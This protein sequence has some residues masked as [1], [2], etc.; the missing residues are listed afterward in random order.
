M[1]LVWEHT[2]GKRRYQI[3]TAGRS[4]RLYTNG[5]L[6]SQYHPGHVFNGGVWDL[7]GLPAMW[8]AD[9]RLSGILML[10][11]GGGTVI[12][13]LHELVEWER[14]VAVERN[15]VHLDISRRFFGLD[16]VPVEL[17]ELDADRWIETYTGG[18]FEL[19]IDDLFADHL[20]EARRA[21]SFSR[22]WYA[23]L[24][25]LLTDRGTLV[26]NFA[27]GREMKRRLKKIPALRRD[28][29]CVYKLTIPSYGNAV[30]VFLRE[31][32]TPDDLSRAVKHIKPRRKR[33]RLRYRI[34]KVKL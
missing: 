31:E 28:F 23:G 34:E 24:C 16:G 29:Q 26:V 30:A 11:V 13:Q 15:P 18:R 2:A 20:G 4:I 1:A 8:H 12:R 17:V 32:R 5:V 9:R 21:V 3:R 22:D 10:G 14:F 27:D 6:H 19:I 33:S 25:D 7:L